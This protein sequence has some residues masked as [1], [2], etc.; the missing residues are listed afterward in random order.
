MSRT[1]AYDLMMK[2]RPFGLAGV[3]YAPLPNQEPAQ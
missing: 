1:Q 3:V 2:L